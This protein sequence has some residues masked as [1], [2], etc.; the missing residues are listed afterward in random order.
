M[1][2]LPTPIK[3]AFFF[4]LLL[5]VV[6][7]LVGVSMSLLL[8]LAFSL[9]IVNPFGRDALKISGITL[10][11]SIVVLGLTLNIKEVVST[12]QSS[13][14]ITLTTIIFAL[15]CGLLLGHLFKLEKN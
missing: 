5:L 13:F 8:G 2:N 3:S 15:G 11:A 14:F 9:L 4:L 10:S 1:L 7:G 12:A 6:T